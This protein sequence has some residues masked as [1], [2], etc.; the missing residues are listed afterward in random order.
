MSYGM[1]QGRCPACRIR[2]VWPSSKG[3]PLAGAHCPRCSKPLVRTVWD[4]KLPMVRIETPVY[5]S[6]RGAA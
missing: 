6:P 4:V 2:F 5:T 1:R 3:L